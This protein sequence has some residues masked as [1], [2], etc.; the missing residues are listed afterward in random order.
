MVN[1][2][3]RL[4]FDT[5]DY[6]E[7]E[8]ATE[9]VVPLIKRLPKAPAERRA[10]TII[11]DKAMLARIWGA[12]AP[13]PL[14]TRPRVPRLSQLCREELEAR[15]KRTSRARTRIRVSFVLVALV[16]LVA[17]VAAVPSA[18]TRVMNHVVAVRAALL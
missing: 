7:R 16:A 13:S 6:S 17:S 4:R 15:D 11:A 1:A 9:L 12:S 3:P 8:E 18:R 14:P 5:L 2:Q 10:V